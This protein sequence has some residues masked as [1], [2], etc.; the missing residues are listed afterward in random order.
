MTD[1][2][3]AVN[4]ADIRE[5]CPDL[6]LKQKKAAYKREWYAK[7]K[8][9]HRANQNAWNALHKE[10]LD[11][12]RKEVRKLSP[13]KNLQESIKLGLKRKGGD[14]TADFMFQMWL[15]QDGYCAVSGIKMIWGGGKAGPINMSID[16]IDQSRGYYK[17]NVRLVCH[18][19]NSFRGQ[20]SD[21]DMLKIALQLVSNMQAK[22]TINKLVK[23]LSYE[24]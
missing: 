24:L 9:R 10:E 7:N 12:K 22:H 19:I 8:E 13:L 5:S 14:I 3:V 16:R 17:D 23:E 6:L 1:S 21:T 18:S 2:T 15:K 4:L 11:E 20:M